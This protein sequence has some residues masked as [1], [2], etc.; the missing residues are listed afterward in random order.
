MSTNVNTVGT[1]EKSP[2]RTLRGQAAVW[3]A[4]LLMLV[5]INIAQLWILAATI[6]AALARHYSSL[7]PLVIASGICFLITLSIIRWWRP[8]SKRFTST[9]YVRDSARR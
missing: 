2:R 4:R 8:T 9:G 3:Q 6:D 5:M 1:D 7:L